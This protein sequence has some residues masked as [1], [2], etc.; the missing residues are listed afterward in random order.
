MKRALKW[1][2]IGVLSVVVLGIIFGE[3]EEQPA[4]S[5]STPTAVPTQAPEGQAS[6]EAEA[7]SKH[8]L[9]GQDYF[10]AGKYLLAL[11][12]F[13][14]IQE[15]SSAPVFL[16]ESYYWLGRTNYEIGS[17]YWA[18]LGPYSDSVSRHYTAAADSYSQVLEGQKVQGGWESYLGRG[19]ANFALGRIHFFDQR[20]GQP[21]GRR[22]DAL[23]KA[24]DDFNSAIEANNSSLEA[25]L[26]RAKYWSLIGESDKAAQ[27][28]ATAR[29][30][31]PGFTMAGHLESLPPVSNLQEPHHRCYGLPGGT[32]PCRSAVNKRSVKP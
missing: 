7:A 2:G 25:L 9:A 6:T 1:L 11:T 12:E 4:A 3:T 23:D 10:D 14:M 30:E 31:W 21:L 16:G 13:K 20:G 15:V 26:E 5:V 32:D 17:N 29:K 22:S 8:N 28:L 19:I 24:I 27:D 18:E